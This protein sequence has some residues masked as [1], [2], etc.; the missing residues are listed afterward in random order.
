MNA[1]ASSAVAVVG[2]PCPRC[3]MVL[4]PSQFNYDHAGELVCPICLARDA[5]EAASEAARASDPKG[6]GALYGAGAAG[7]LLG[8]VIFCFSALGIWFFIAS[9]L[10]ILIGGGTL[11]NLLR[12]D[13]AKTRLGTAGFLLV[14]AMSVVSILLGLGAIGFGILYVVLSA[15]S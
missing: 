10:P 2:A 13:T 9:P 14:A 15:S 3:Q 1:G 4:D 11:V 7:I 6:V 12:D 5:N 8:T